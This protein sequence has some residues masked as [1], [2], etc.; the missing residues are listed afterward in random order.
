VPG[1]RVVQVVA[2]TD[3]VLVTVIVSADTVYVPGVGHV[4]TNG[5][6]KGALECVGAAV[7]ILLY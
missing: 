7:T 5:V 6:G 1:V 3:F 2:K 4:V